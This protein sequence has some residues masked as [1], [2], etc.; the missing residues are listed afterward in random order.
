MRKKSNRR[1]KYI[2]LAQMN[3]TP[4]VDIVFVL[5]IVFM[6]TAPMLTV[7]VPIDLPD[8][9]AAQLQND[10]K[11]PLIISI[12]GKNEIFIQDKKMEDKKAMMALIDSISES[13]KNFTIYVRGDKNLPYGDV[14]QTMGI[15]ADAGYSKV[16]LIANLP[17]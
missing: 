9:K 13:N 4:L 3:M 16:S 7:G 11:D 6:I 5:L 15:I 12:N 8:T 1:K 14:M 10:E 17:Q 2:P